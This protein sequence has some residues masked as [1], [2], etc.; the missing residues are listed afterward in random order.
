MVHLQHVCE[1]DT[2]LYQTS[3][4]GKRNHPEW[5]NELPQWATY[6]HEHDG[7]HNLVLY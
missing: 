5:R 1:T 2:W 6:T 3:L 4:S 7:I